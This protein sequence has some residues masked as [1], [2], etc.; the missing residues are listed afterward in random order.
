MPVQLSHKYIFG[1]STTV[2]QNGA[3]LDDQHVAFAAGNVVVLNN[4]LDRKQ[5]VINSFVDP[6]LEGC[7]CLC[8]DPS[9]KL[10]AVGLRSEKPEIHVFDVKSLR[11]KKQLIHAEATAKC[12]IVA[13]Q[14]THNSEKLVALSSSPDSTVLVFQWLKGKKLFEV[15]LAE[16]LTEPLGAEIFKSLSLNPVDSETMV[17]TGPGAL[18]FFRL[19]EDRAQ[20][21]KAADEHLLAVVGSQGRRSVITAMCWLKQPPDF[22][23]V[24]NNLGRLAVYGN[25]EFITF[26]TVN[27]QLQGAASA[28]LAAKSA[29][30]P[31]EAGAA[32]AAL[33]TRSTAVGVA[34]LVC[35]TSGLVVGCSDGGFRFLARSMTVPDGRPG[36]YELAHSWFPSGPQSGLGAAKASTEAPTRA[37]THM[38][39]SE[40]EDEL[41]A[42]F[43]D[44]ALLR[45]NVAAPA[46]VKGES[47]K[48]VSALAHI[49]GVITGLDVCVRKPLAVTCSLDRTIRVWNY[50]EQRLELTRSV[51]EDPWSIAFHPS[52]L[53]IVVGFGDKLRLMNL[54]MDD[55]RMYRELPVK[56]CREVQFSHGGQYFAAANQSNV[57]LVYSFYTCEK[58]ADLRGHSGKVKSIVWTRD[59]ATLITCGHDGAVYMWD[60][61]AGKRLGEFVQKG[62]HFNAALA[63]DEGIYAAASDL[64]LKEFDM[65]ELQVAKETGTQVP[66]S[67][68]VLNNAENFLFAGTGL[69][70][71]PGMVRSYE[72]PVS[73]DYV[74]YA[75]MGTP[76]TR[77]RITPDDRTLIATDESGCV[78]IFDIKDRSDNRALGG[79]GA[80]T[81]GVGGGKEKSLATVQRMNESA[82]PW[83][84]EILITRS[85]LEEKNALMAENRGKV[86]ELQ[87]HNEYQLRLRDMSYSEKVKEIQEKFMQDVEQEK[88]K[89]ELL[90]EEKNDMQM[91]YEE[92]LKQMDD[93]HQHELQDEE[94]TYQEQIMA[95]VEDYQRLIGER[96]LQ[97][98]RWEDQRDALVATHERYVQ[99]L[100]DDFEQKLEED[101]QLHQ[102][103]EE[104]KKMAEREYTEMQN[105]LED[106]IDTEIENLRDRYDT[107]LNHER[108][109]TLRYKGEN[110]IMK[111]RFTVLQQNIEDNKEVI[112]GCVEKEEELK[113]QIKALEEEI[114]AHKREIKSRDEI[115]GSKE[116]KIYDLKK[117][118][119]EL[120]KFKFVLDYKIKEL[121]RQI[122]PRETEIANMKHQIKDMDREL[123]QYHKSNA[124]LDLM[125]GDLRVKLDDMQ[126]TIGSNRKLIGDAESAII[127]FKGEVHECVQFIQDPVLL[128]D[129]VRKLSTQHQIAS[130][131]VG[132]TLDGNVAHEYH[133]HKD[134]LQRT[135]KTLKDKFTEDIQTHQAGVPH[136]AFFLCV[137]VVPSLTCIIAERCS[138]PPPPPTG[139]EH[140]GDARQHEPHPRH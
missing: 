22:F 18:R 41:V 104:E 76:V 34:A 78:V 129:A 42:G 24:G 115:I 47:M 57:V 110:G 135:F 39:L 4:I 6:S 105:Q 37:V 131:E 119:Q 97:K 46:A 25:G 140:A 8:L 87:L 56:L 90:R 82:M 86:E 27:L 12:G 53:H 54:L 74:E 136:L 128:A 84:E 51:S 59:D 64:Q 16:G 9:R 137:S 96:N 72:Y 80:G 69:D 112:K 98:E 111:K 52:G 50:A 92:S 33:A 123:E 71:L 109:L 60:W 30:S 66:L 70:G 32:S 7:S 91:E 10:L 139:G 117:K 108:E 62:I 125:I 20:P 23:V 126:L 26:L 3:F 100:T 106:D 93:K 73:A 138:C 5:R 130:P 28:D 81:G 44:G 124:Q 55:I 103:L 118:N 21:I 2:A 102:Q 83:S 122:E 31:G 95:E 58:L 121:K 101:R 13:L 38:S 19:T 85:D 65:P 1:S 116:K 48:P 127:Q 107:Q 133:R 134:Y 36:M 40:S 67:Q 35:V 77:L 61:E 11:K 132:A 43:D 45:V 63:T 99:E 79:G 75:C 120:E 29:M 88:N 15:K 113:Q 114:K 49:P 68:I 89:Y 17:V 94:N 14:F